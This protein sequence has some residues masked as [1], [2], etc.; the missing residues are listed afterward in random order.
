MIVTL[1]I[2]GA[3]GIPLAFTLLDQLLK[4]NCKVH[5][6]IT[7][8]GIITAKQET[9]IS[10]SGN[11]NATRDNLVKELNL[12]NDENLFAYTNNDW[13][14]PMASGSSVSDAMVICP[15]S[16]ASLGKIANGIGDDL[17][18][19]AADVVL[20]ERKN[21]ILVPRE[22]PLSAIHLANMQKLA[23]LNVCILP[24]MPAFYTHPKS[25]QDIVDFIVG[26]I[27][28]QLGL[29]NNLVKPWGAK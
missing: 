25:V 11:P 12:I 13:Y 2:T 4:L 24:P 29:V 28:D 9:G 7:N 22:T 1:G 27:L 8:A 23:A 3:T 17:L 18:C 21:L 20:K 14:A 19:R 5:L 15:C 10:L 16:M 6:V 26:R